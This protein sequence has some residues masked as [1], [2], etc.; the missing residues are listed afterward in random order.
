MA[1]QGTLVR[2]LEYGLV[3][4]QKWVAFERRKMA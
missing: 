1:A 4:T 3:S 2:E